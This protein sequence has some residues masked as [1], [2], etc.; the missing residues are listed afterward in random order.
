MGPRKS[1]ATDVRIKHIE[2]DIREI[3]HCLKAQTTL[4]QDVARQEQKVN[5]MDLRLQINEKKVDR[6]QSRTMDRMWNAITIFFSV[7]LSSVVA[8]IMGRR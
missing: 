1:N 3:K 6:L 2:E 4:L 5:D 8:Y 7:V